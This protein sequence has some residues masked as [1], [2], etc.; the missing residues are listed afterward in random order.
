MKNSNLLFSLSILSVLLAGCSTPWI[1]G[2][3]KTEQ[4]WKDYKKGQPY[5]ESGIESQNTQ[6]N[7]EEEWFVQDWVA[8]HNSGREMIAGFYRSDILR[9]QTAQDGKPVLVVGPQFYRLSGYDKRRVVT[10]VDS[11]YGITERGQ[12]PVILLHDW[13]T[14]RQ[15]GVYG[16]DGL[17][18]E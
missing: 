12:S 16:K 2:T 3:S 1:G 17:Q 15:I 6:W 8:Q 10:S 9:E 5:L 4:K 13:K 14:R 11:I 18:L 7:H